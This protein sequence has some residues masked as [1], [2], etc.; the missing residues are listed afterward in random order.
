MKTHLLKSEPFFF[1]PSTKRLFGSY[2]YPQPPNPKKY[3]IVLCYPIGPEYVRSHRVIHQLAKRLSAVGFCVLKFDYFGSGDSHGDFEEGNIK[4][5]TEDIFT[6]IEEMRARLTLE[7]VCLIGL[8][9]GATL[10][11][12]TAASRNDV[13]ALVL[14]EPV[15]KGN[16]YLEELVRAHNIY[17]KDR[18][19]RLLYRKM[20]KLTP[21]EI[22]GYPLTAEQIEEI[23]GFDLHTVDIASEAKVILLANEENHPLK[24]FQK[25]LSDKR[26]SIEY[27]IIEDNKMWL[28]SPYKRIVPI[29]TINYL[30]SWVQETLDGI[31]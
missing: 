27:K 14:W 6:A 30:V 29:Q 2:Y 15:I 17:F 21:N 20:S 7:K 25:H 19:P 28:E 31:G 4:Q 8:R 3:G 18:L 9:F 5:W 13:E 16:T 12:V 1:G 10:S 24:N 26:A 22:L 11:L 23:G